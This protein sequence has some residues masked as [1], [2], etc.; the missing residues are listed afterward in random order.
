MKDDFFDF[1][2]EPTVE[3][4]SKARSYVITDEE[5][6][7]YSDDIKKLEMLLQKEAYEEVL[8]YNNINVVL[9]PRTHMM[10]KYA[11]KQLGKEK[12]EQAEYFLAHRILEGIHATGSGSKEQ[13]YKV[14][15]VEDERDFLGFIGETSKMQSLIKEERI[16]DLITTESGK[17]IY[18][19]I[20]ECYG[21]VANFSFEDMLE[22]LG[23][24]EEIENDSE[25]KTVSPT[26]KKT[27]KKWWK[28]W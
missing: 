15:R 20:T 18:F 23:I 6:S 4:F 9:S 27:Q 12:D 2:K 14:L 1:L 19:D 17:S 3:A 25:E 16:Y 8:A 26:P 11:A 24:D 28:F 13:P 22:S 21:K 7:P 5:Y 10:K